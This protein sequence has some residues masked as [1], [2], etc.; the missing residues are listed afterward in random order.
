MLAGLA[1]KRK[2]PKQEEAEGKPWDKPNIVTGATV[3]VC[4]EK[5]ASTLRFKSIM[6]NTINLSSGLRGISK[7]MENC[8]DNADV[9]KEGL[10]KTGR[11]NIVSKD[12]GVHW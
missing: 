3:Q 10:E 9:L 2:W 12:E 6:L 11:L 7:I 1:F 5:F 8:R 4:W